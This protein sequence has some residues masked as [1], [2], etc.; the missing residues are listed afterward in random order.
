MICDMS[1]GGE[2][3]VDGDLLY[4]NGHFQIL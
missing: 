2:I 3:W 1:E 4:K